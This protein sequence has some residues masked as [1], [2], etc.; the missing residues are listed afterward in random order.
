MARHVREAST[1][2][3][4]TT[5]PPPCEPGSHTLDPAASTDSVLH[6]FDTL[7][8]VGA[9]VQDDLTLNLPTFTAA[10]I[11]LTAD[12]SQLVGTLHINALDPFPGV[13][14]PFGLT[15]I[16]LAAVNPLLAVFV[17]GSNPFPGS[18]S[19]QLA[20]T[21]FTF[22]TGQLSRIRSNVTASKVV[23]HIDDSA[24]A[25]PSDL[26]LTDTTFN[27]WVIPGSSLTPALTTAI[28]TER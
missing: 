24:T 2:R 12:A 11:L 5:L 22:G 3:P 15:T 10:A 16:T 19:Y 9:L 6:A 28:S 17:V 8:V 25:R 21:T 7:Y 23:L 13:L 18:A 4:P 20:Q 27:N 14:A 26:M 1:R